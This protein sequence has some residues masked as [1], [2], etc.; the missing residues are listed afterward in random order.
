MLDQMAEEGEA[1]EADAFAHDLAASAL[2]PTPATAA[3]GPAVAALMASDA[4]QDPGIRGRPGVGAR[5]GCRGHPGDCQGRVRG[6]YGAEV[7]T[8]GLPER[9]RQVPLCVAS[10][11]E[12]AAAQ[13][14]L[15]S[16]L[17]QSSP[18]LSVLQTIGHLTSNGALA[19]TTTR[20]A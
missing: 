16:D 7:G 6:A 19:E 20:D 5:T 14:H 15:N 18:V 12:H 13:N 17:P 8:L 11:I 10:P 9:Q 1:L 4:T 2:A 3:P